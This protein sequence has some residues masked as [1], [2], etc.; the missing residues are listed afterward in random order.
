MDHPMDISCSLNK[1]RIG[2]SLGGALVELDALYEAQSPWSKALLRSPALFRAHVKDFPR[3][4]QINARAC[5]RV[6]SS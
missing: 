1:H 4:D 6:Q 2:H 5:R 3:T